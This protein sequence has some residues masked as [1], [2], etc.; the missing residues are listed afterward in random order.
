MT[1]PCID[2]I[3]DDPRRPYMFSEQSSD[4]FIML[5]QL[6]AGVDSTVSL[7]SGTLRD[8]YLATWQHSSRSSKGRGGVLHELPSGLKVPIGLKTLHNW[9]PPLAP[10]S[11]Y[12]SKGVG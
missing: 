12:S 1:M 11:G 10:L 4:V 7:R 6:R 8:S 9:Y 2:S 5:A 3:P